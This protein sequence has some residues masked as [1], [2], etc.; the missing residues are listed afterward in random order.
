MDILEKMLSLFYH[1]RDTVRA[2][3]APRIWR[4]TNA[5]T[6][7]ELMPP[8]GPEEAALEA[9]C[10]AVLGELAV[11]DP[12]FHMAGIQVSLRVL[13]CDAVWYGVL[14]CGAVCGCARR[15]CG[16]RPTI[17]NGGFSGLFVSV[18]VYCSVLQCVAVCCI[19][20]LCS[21]CSTPNLHD[22]YSGLSPC[23][24]VCW[25]C[26]A[27][28]CSMVQLLQCGAVWCIVLQCESV[29]QCASVYCSVLQDVAAVCCSA[30]TP[31][32]TRRGCRTRSASNKGLRFQRVLW[33]NA[34]CCSVWQQCVAVC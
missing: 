30:L 34:V 1:A 29:L 7:G 4:E 13:Q 2:K 33:F 28:C 22:G 5:A 21:Q 9:E 19:V 26:V 17:P 10:G 25:Q 32:F 11:L 6:R 8:E 12:Q 18:A 27:S 16:A 15:A 24:A 20:C 14:Q 3:N 23:V 31:S